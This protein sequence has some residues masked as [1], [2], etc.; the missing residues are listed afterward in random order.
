MCLS[1]NWWYRDIAW[2][3]L[4][5]CQGLSLCC[6]VWWQSYR[7]VETQVNV[8]KSQYCFSL[9]KPA[10]NRFNP[11]LCTRG[12]KTQRPAHPS[13]GVESAHMGR[14]WTYTHNCCYSSQ[15]VDCATNRRL[16]LHHGRFWICNNK[17]CLPLA[18]SYHFNRAMLHA[19]AVNSTISSFIQNYHFMNGLCCRHNEAKCQIYS[20]CVNYYTTFQAWCKVY[21]QSFVS[22]STVPQTSPCLFFPH[23]W[24]SHAL[25]FCPL[26]SWQKFLHYKQQ[27][28][29]RGV[30]FVSPPFSPKQGQI[31]ALVPTYQ[32]RK[33][34]DKQVRFVDTVWTLLPV[35]A[36]TT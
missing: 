15:E 2:L 3:S 25:P 36:Y 32:N 6:E 5:L 26:Q 4:S 11:N 34:R 24:P 27:G 13:V 30:C 22:L 29:E 1:K 19:A 7:H 31:L 28:R 35:F 8:N 20:E 9:T 16:C 18:C 10:N 21:C 12:G 23:I 33:I 17:L 14:S